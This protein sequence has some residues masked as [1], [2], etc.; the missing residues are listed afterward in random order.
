[1]LLNYEAASFSQSE[2]TSPAAE[3]DK[4]FFSFMQGKIS[5]FEASNSDPHMCQLFDTHTVTTVTQAMTSALNKTP[6]QLLCQVICIL[7]SVL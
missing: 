5:E 3:A 7:C 2:I 6:E 1:M 4:S